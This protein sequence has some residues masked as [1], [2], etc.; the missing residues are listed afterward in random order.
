MRI[1]V[2]HHRE[3]ALSHSCLAACVGMVRRARGEA[4]DEVAMMAGRELTSFPEEQAA[5]L[6]G[7]AFLGYIEDDDLLRECDAVMGGDQ[8]L[9]V[10]ICLPLHVKLC[11]PRPGGSAS[12]YGHLAPPGDMG[13]PHAVLVV[14]AADGTVTFLDPWYPAEG[15]PFVVARAVL[16]QMFMG[17]VIRVPLA[18]AR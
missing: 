8:C 7:G 14:D 4:H 12:R 9:I 6:L 10:R 13:G 16:V 1:G 11:G 17:D 5:T 3:Q 2:E 15:Q 18:P